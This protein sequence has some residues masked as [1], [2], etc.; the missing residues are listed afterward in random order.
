MT[1]LGGLF[2]ILNKMKAFNN[3]TEIR[4]VMDYK[5]KVQELQSKYN[6]VNTA[7]NNLV[8]QKHQLEGAISALSDIDKECKCKDNKKNDK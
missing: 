7:I 8:V 3:T 6:N 5:E 2:S 4:P 1:S